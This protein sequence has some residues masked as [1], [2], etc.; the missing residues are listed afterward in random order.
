MDIAPAI[1]RLA[2]EPDKSQTQ[3]IGHGEGPLLVIAGP[4]SGKTH[5]LQ[6]RALNLLL[7]GRTLPSELVLCTFGRRAA[8]ELRQ[9]LTASALSCGLPGGVAEASIGTIHGLCHRL[10]LPHAAMAGLARDYRVLNEEQQRLLLHQEYEAVFGPDRDILSRRGWRDGGHTVAEAA[11]YFDRICD[12][13]IDADAIAASSRP[14]IAALGRSCQRYRQLLLRHNAVDFAHLQVWAHRVLQDDEVAAAARGAVSHLMV[15]EFQD[16]SRV[17]MRILERLAGNRGN[18]V[19]AGDDDQ[20][21][22][23]FRGASVS[24][25]LEFAS[26][27]PGRRTAELTTNYR[28]HR[29][30][31]AAVDRWMDTAAPWDIGGRSFR[32]AKDIVPHEPGAHR[33]YPAVISILGRDPAHEA[34]QLAELLLFLKHNGVIG[35]YGQAAL[36]LHSVKDAVSG[37]YL[38]GMERAGIPV[39]CEPAGQVRAYGA[40]E[41]LVTTIHQAKGREWDV[42]VSGSLNGPSMETD[43]VGRALAEFGVYSGEPEAFIADYDKARQHYVAF[44]RARNLLALTASGEPQ[45][46]FRSIWEG[47]PRWPWLDRQSLARQR[48]GPAGAEPPRVVEIDRLERL[49][50]SLMNPGMAVSVTLG[51]RLAVAEESQPPPEAASKEIPESSGPAAARGHDG[52]TDSPAGAAGLPLCCA[53]LPSPWPVAPHLSSTACCLRSDI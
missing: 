49:V 28:S 15:D 27:F 17:Q 43:R 11:R 8:R 45:D 47:A 23:R 39:R 37:P 9:R 26:R 14:F 52:L 51:D 1:L 20:S 29:E 22:Y 41:V 31:V 36:L 21:I 40:G 35:R 5:T 38:D 44:T 4:G 30:I 50:V 48:F 2:P 7:S 19:A 33:D 16:T 13:L 3:V 32:F 18:I 24:N 34:Q 46:R 25:L 42:V 10:L 12:E 53:L 6:L